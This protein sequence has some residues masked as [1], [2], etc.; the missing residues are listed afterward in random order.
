[1]SQTDN[2]RTRQMPR[3][4]SYG[5][6]VRLFVNL[7]KESLFKSPLLDT[8]TLLKARMPIVKAIIM[9]FT[10]LPYKSSVVKG[11]LQNKLKVFGF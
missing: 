2:P 1:M 10:I 7:H 6:P 11:F 8:G 5:T 4:R 9:Q 3:P